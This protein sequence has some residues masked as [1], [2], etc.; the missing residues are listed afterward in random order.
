MFVERNVFHLKFGAAKQAVNL[1]KD[2]LQKVHVSDN[3]I[4]ARLLTDITGRGYTIVLELSYSN[5]EELE[6]AKCSLTKKEGWKEFY[7]QF[8]PLCEY[9][10]R[11]QYK[12]EL[13]Y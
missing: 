8:I 2:Y 1:W 7:Q 10:E 12:L 11:T 5:Y 6:P 4:R 3:T 9:S 13:V